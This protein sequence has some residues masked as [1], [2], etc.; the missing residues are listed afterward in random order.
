[1]KGYDYNSSSSS[2]DR[3][4]LTKIAFYLGAA[5]ALVLII[6]GV[7]HLNDPVD[8]DRMF[9][10][11]VTLEGL[12]A[13]SGLYLID[14]VKGKR[15]RVKPKAFRPFEI[16]TLTRGIIIF[17]I[18]GLIQILIQVPLKI[19][20]G[21]MA[22]AIVFAAPSEEL[23]FRGV[24]ISVTVEA[25]KIT[26]RGRSKKRVLLAISPIEIGGIVL[27]SLAFMSI[28]INYYDNPPLLAIVF[29]SGLVLGF[30]YWYWDDL[31]AC[32]IAHFILNSLIAYQTFWMVN[33]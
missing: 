25:A 5:S 6:I 9:G 20:S 3:S 28:H 21:E 11:K 29:L 13:F 22:L 18:L 33:V 14:M 24:M 2:R 1:M 15:I 19:K 30:A 31:T 26:R 10:I 4:S 17:G 32:I 16:N 8:F 23:F 12:F 7:R 27:S